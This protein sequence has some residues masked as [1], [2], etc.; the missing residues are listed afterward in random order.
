MW[1]CSQGEY[2]GFG[3]ALDYDIGFAALL[4]DIGKTRLPATLLD[5]Q[6]SL[7]ETEWTVM[8]KHPV[9]GAALLASLNKVPE[10]AMVVAYEHHMKYDGT[11]YPE[12]RR[13]VRKQHIVSQIVAI[14]DFYCT[15][16]AGLPQ[17]K[18]LSNTSIMG[19]LLETA[20]TEFNPVLV[21][22]FVRAM[23]EI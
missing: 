21:D 11:G 12:T 16:S 20:G 17:R 4:H 10:I 6:D 14:A 8:K 22:N 18:P 3:S 9:Y 23:G 19:L 7:S 15:L 2:L 13:M 1:R 5:R